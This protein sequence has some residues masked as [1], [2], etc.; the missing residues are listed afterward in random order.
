MATSPLLPQLAVRS[1]KLPAGWVTH[2]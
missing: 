2:P 1:T